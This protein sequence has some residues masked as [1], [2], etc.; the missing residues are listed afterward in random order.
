METIHGDKPML[1][2]E[3]EI[4]FYVVELRS[5]SKAA[6]RLN[7]SKSFISKKI[8]KLEHDLKVTLISRSTRNLTITE[9]G[10][11]FYHYCANI[12]ETGNEAYSMINDI[13]GKP[14]GTL[15]ISIPPALGL[16]FLSPMISDFMLKHPDV[17]LDVEL[18]NKLV[19]VLKGGYDLVLRTAP[20]E[21]SNLIAQK[22]LSIKNVICAS[23]IYLQTHTIP[24]TPQDLEQHHFATYRHTKK[25]EKIILQ[26]NTEPEI[27]FIKNHFKSNSMD[28]IKKILL[29]NTCLSIL[30]EF[31][32]EKE[33]TMGTIKICLPEYKLPE[34]PIY[35]MYP[36][37]KF[38]QPKLKF[39]I[40][41][42]KNYVAE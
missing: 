32:I 8:S 23:T 27:V 28:L 2:E 1:L 36:E 30:P 22:I 13:Q 11:Q 39:F 40:E 25:V 41:L 17:M 21:S 3:M 14:S 15:K 20:L 16:H 5:F 35:A 18:E 33:L 34:S 31:M 24:T 29:N 7:V 42:L 10:N 9:A 38:M 19:D 12:V 6:A 4:F 26:K 37:R